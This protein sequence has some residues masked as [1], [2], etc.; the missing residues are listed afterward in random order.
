MTTS[1]HRMIDD[2]R[3]LTPFMRSVYHVVATIP[4]GAVMTYAQVACAIGKPQATRAVGNALNRNPFAPH[5]PC[6][7]VIRS[8]GSVGGFASGSER[9]QLLLQRE[10]SM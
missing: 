4:S 7:R 1:V 6:H 3:E 8:D 10:G 5:V 9:K 2:A